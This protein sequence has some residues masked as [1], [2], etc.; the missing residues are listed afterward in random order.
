MSRPDT[1]AARAPDLAAFR[2]A[3]HALVDGVAEYL[4]KL[5]SRAVWSRSS[6]GRCTS[7]A[8]SPNVLAD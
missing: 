1:G 5:P 3:G 4:V 7:G 2:H 8:A 6:P